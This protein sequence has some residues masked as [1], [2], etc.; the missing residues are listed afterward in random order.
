MLMPA[1]L[2][3]GC[4][5]VMS[6]PMMLPWMMLPVPVTMSKPAVPLPEMRLP[7]G[8]PGVDVSPPMVL[9]PRFIAYIHA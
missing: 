5:P 8:V 7:G 6:A 4:V 3:N 1:A 2:P 9:P